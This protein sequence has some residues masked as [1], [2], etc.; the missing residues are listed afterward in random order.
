MSTLEF[1]GP[2]CLEEQGRGNS[3]SLSVGPGIHCRGRQHWRG[4]QER[5]AGDSKSITTAC[6]D[7]GDA[8]TANSMRDETKE[9]QG[10]IT[11][12]TKLMN[13]IGWYKHNASRT[14]GKLAFSLSN[15]PG[16]FQNEDFVFV[17]MLMMRGMPTGT[18]LEL[19]HR[20]MR[21]TVQ[22]ADQDPDLTSLG[23]IH[24]HI[25]LRNRFVMGNFHAKS[26]LPIGQHCASLVR[27]VCYRFLWVVDDPSILPSN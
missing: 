16:A 1:T 26:L 7:A 4:N 2:G 23:T 17:R 22:F 10:T 24:S 14:D 11:S 9:F 6:R 25:L 20:E 21:C 3:T 5:L 12:S 19:S 8:G 27:M 13:F 15:R 18:N